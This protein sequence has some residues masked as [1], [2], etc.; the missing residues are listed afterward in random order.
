MAAEFGT[1][2]N[3]LQHGDSFFPS[4][5][6]SF[7]WGLEAL[8]ESGSLSTP[9]TIEAFIAGQL[10]SRWA[11][12]DR[13]VL[14]AAHAR[15]D[16]LDAVADID[17]LVELTTSAAELRRA[18]R[19]MGEAMLSVFARLDD[20]LAAS[21]RARVKAGDACG[22]ISVMQGMLWAHA[23]LPEAEALALSAHTFYTGLLGAGLRLGCLTHIDS[24][25]L[26]HMARAEATRLAAEP[27]VPLDA[28]S[29][30]GIEAEIAVM[31]HASQD[32]RLFSN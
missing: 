21:Y 27:V 5:A 4:G 1:L 23:G 12:Y 31:R 26:L 20:P 6:V 30:H 17:H 8:V 28:I 16:D 11:C 13:T 19:R 9:E 24:Q 3:V 15:A 22:H 25:R 18:S 32:L 10:Q 14:L 7:S 2:L 29:A